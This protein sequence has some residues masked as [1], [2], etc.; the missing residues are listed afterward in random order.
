MN[1][2]K[3]NIGKIIFSFIMAILGVTFN[4]L[5]YFAVAKIVTL[6]INGTKDINSF[7]PLFFMASLGFVF[8]VVFHGIST[9]ISHNLAFRIVEKTRKELVKKLHCLY[10]GT[11]EEKSSGKWTQCL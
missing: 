2:L 10:M 5:A 9:F 6:L 1:Y 3:E 11:I 8:G 7:V 4:V